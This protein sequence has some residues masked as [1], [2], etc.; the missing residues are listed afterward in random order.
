MLSLVGEQMPDLPDCCRREPVW[1]PPAALPAPVHWCLV[2]VPMTDG[3]AGR[4]P[5]ERLR[6]NRVLMFLT[7]GLHRGLPVL[8]DLPMPLSS[9]LSRREYRPRHPPVLWMPLRSD[10][11]CSLLPKHRKDLWAP[12]SRMY[13]AGLPGHVPYM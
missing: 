7:A 2:P 10:Q 8:P 1:A 5:R 13:C 9:L 6:K 3:S 12:M 11:W 4:N